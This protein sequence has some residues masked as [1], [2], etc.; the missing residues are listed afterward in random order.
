MSSQKIEKILEKY[1]HGDTSLAEERMLR[2]FFRK[3]EVPAHLAELKDQFSLF[4]EE[5]NEMLPDNFDDGVLDAINSQERKSR[6]SRRAFIYYVSGVAATI[7]ILVTVYIQF[8]PFTTTYTED[9]ATLAYE[10]ASRIFG[11]VSEKINNSTTSLEKVARFDEGM[12]NLKSIQ[13]FDEGVSKAKPVSRFK[14]I[15]DL[16]INPAP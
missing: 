2:E 13:K 11:M 8:D 3:D 12:N 15:T 1:F 9:D 16:F 4:D 5:S 10:Q 14:Q 7:L 6:A